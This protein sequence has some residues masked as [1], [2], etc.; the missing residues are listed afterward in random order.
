MKW[1]L[2]ILLL[3]REKWYAIPAM[4]SGDAK[5]AGLAGLLKKN[6]DMNPG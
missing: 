6:P 2:H 4:M 5:E 3:G 1:L